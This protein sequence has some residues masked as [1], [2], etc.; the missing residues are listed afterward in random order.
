MSLTS[1]MTKKSAHLQSSANLCGRVFMMFM[2]L[3]ECADNTLIVARSIEFVLQIE[4]PMIVHLVEEVDP[5]RFTEAPSMIPSSTPS[6]SP[7]LNPSSEPSS[8]PSSNP[9][10]SPSDE[11]SQTPSSSPSDHPSRTPS[12]SPSQAPTVTYSESPS[13]ITQ[14][15]ATYGEPG[16]FNYNPNDGEYGPDAWATVEDSS[17][18]KSWSKWP[19][20]VWEFKLHNQ[21]D[22]NWRPSPID[23]C[24][25]VGVGEDY[26]KTMPLNNVNSPCFEYHRILTAKGDWE[27]D[28]ET[29][30]QMHILPSKLRMEYSVRDCAYQDTWGAKNGGSPVWF[31]LPAN[32]GGKYDWCDWEPPAADFPNH[33]NGH[34]QPIHIDIKIPSEHTICGKRFDAEFS[35]WHIHPQRQ[36][37]IVMSTLIEIGE[38]NGELQ[39]AIDQWQVKYDE[40]QISC[41]WSRNRELKE[42]KNILDRMDNFLQYG[43]DE[44]H[45]TPRQDFHT[46]EDISH[47]TRNTNNVRKTTA[48]S[49]EK[50]GFNSY[51]DLIEDEAKHILKKRKQHRQEKEVR[52][53]INFNP[54]H[55]DI[56]K[57]IWF[58]GYWGS[59]TEPPCAEKFV[60][61]IIMDAPMEI[62]LEQFEQLQTLLFTYRN[63]QCVKTSVAHQKSVARPTQPFNDRKLWRCNRERWDELYDPSKCDGHHGTQ[64]G[65]LREEQTMI[66]PVPTLSPTKAKKTR[67]DHTHTFFN[68]FST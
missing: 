59:M 25:G 51:F 9:S 63:P 44:E 31:P 32:K 13:S 60:N 19:N 67:N 11:P 48:S 52:K 6:L 16:Y 7:S 62:S 14:Y 40:D 18:F 21:C 46:E 24:D 22:R 23:V 54:Y 30:I 34:V 49:E 58:Y 56:Y 53:N 29:R 39:K 35:V 65:C 10:E 45:F 33:W 41:E 3:L 26:N 37:A 42:Q 43:V 4:D 15:A 2:V 36:A 27:I 17:E 55:K 8:N 57:S 47:N 5:M 66:I 38:Y 12:I 20:E 68:L 28:D 61:W 64:Y 50:Q 1:K